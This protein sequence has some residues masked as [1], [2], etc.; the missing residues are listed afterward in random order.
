MSVSAEL[1]G[2]A[3]F[4]GRGRMAP[5]PTPEMADPHG[6][7]GIWPRSEGV[8]TGVPEAA[9]ARGKE[10]GNSCPAPRNLP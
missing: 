7:R 10:N 1:G 9:E 4:T 3:G 2:E 5:N 6:P 8:T